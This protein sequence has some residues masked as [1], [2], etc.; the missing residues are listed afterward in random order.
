MLKY[1]KKFKKVN[2][3]EKCYDYMTN[4]EIV[5][6]DFQ[7]KIVRICCIG[8]VFLFNCSPKLFE[9]F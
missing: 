4:L 1:L 5:T 9:P 2:F 8:V 7:S 3:N 6:Y